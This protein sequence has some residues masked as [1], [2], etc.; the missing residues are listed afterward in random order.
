MSE[1]KKLAEN[2]LKSKN[3]PS[4]A[5][6]YSE[7]LAKAVLVMHEAI[8]LAISNQ[9]SMLSEIL[10]HREETRR[11]NHYSDALRCVDIGLAAQ[12]INQLKSYIAEAEKIASGK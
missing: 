9:S 11:R 7:Q 10:Y 1:I 5:I 4:A 12:S 8:E 2:V 6:R 3:Y